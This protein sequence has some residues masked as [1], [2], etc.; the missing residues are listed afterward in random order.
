M[1]FR[2]EDILN[3]LETRSAPGLISAETF[4]RIKSLGALLPAGITY[5]LGFESR[6][7]DPQG[8]VDFIL[9]PL[10]PEGLEIIAGLDTRPPL[11]SVLAR[12]RNW[13][14][15]RDLCRGWAT[16][17][18]PLHNTTLC[19]WIEFDREQLAQAVPS[20]SLVFVQLQRPYCASEIYEPLAQAIHI[21]LKGCSLE[22]PLAKDLRRC[23]ELI[24]EKGMMTLCG[25]PVAR[26]A[27]AF[28]VVVGDLEP[29]QIPEY[30]SSAG[31][32]GNVKFLESVIFSLVGYADKHSINLDLDRRG[33]GKIGI[34]FGI[35]QEHS[36]SSDPRWEPMLDFL[37]SQGWCRREKRNALLAWPKPVT[38]MHD[39]KP[40][41]LRRFI[42]HIK[43]AFEA[44]RRVTAKAYVGLIW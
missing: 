7:A 2:A 21:S 22:Q 11:A 9:R 32:K 18:S 8:D 27:E 26:P 25:L 24:P 29:D 35:P 12:D 28:R 30:V 10:A 3:L 39:P 14:S 31:W 19:L 37:V 40:I 41:L 36:E 34:E 1:P 42:S 15:L 5:G 6:L 38:L 20:P 23:I 44:G 4:D 16:P 33:I 43:L 17:S 13:L